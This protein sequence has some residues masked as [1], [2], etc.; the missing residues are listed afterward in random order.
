MITLVGKPRKTQASQAQ[1][2]Y[3]FHPLLFRDGMVGKPR[4]THLPR[5]GRERRNEESAPR[6][7]GGLTGS[8]T[9]LACQFFLVSG[10]HVWG[11]KR[12]NAEES[13]RGACD[14][15]GRDGWEASPNPKR[16]LFVFSRP[17][18][19]PF[20]GRDGWDGPLNPCLQKMANLRNTEPVTNRIYWRRNKPI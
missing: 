7:S 16:Y 2:G 13:A 10:R 19:L 15:Q 14:S 20:S 11:Q 9:G 4:E 5:F 17:L 6:A 18:R 1:K 8:P 3:L 12:R